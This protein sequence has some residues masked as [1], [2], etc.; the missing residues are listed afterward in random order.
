MPK[1]YLLGQL[2][3]EADD[4]GGPGTAPGRALQLLACLALRPGTEVPRQHLAELLWPDSAEPQ[5]LT[6]LRRELHTLRGLLGG[7]TAEDGWT[8]LHGNAGLH[9]GRATLCWTEAPGQSVDVALFRTEHDAAFREPAA[10]PEAFLAHADA[11]L[12]A[13]QGDLLPGDATDWVEREREML[14]SECV[15]LCDRSV[16]ACRSASRPARAAELARRRIRL[17]P[18]EESGYRALMVLQAEA[19]DR[20]AALATFHRCARTL[21]HGLG[22]GPDP[23]TLAL[24]E[25]I[26]L[27]GAGEDPARGGH[28]NAGRTVPP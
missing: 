8:G 3:V 26:A 15:Q 7:G 13:Y 5:A 17:E 10:A 21:R 11:A 4:G 27:H 16:A 9:G 23:A 14:R 6:N 19:G 20:G 28:P 18:F 2:R 22:V 24:R 1:I 12:E 25:S